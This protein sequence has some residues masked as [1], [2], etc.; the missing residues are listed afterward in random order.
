MDA[1]DRIKSLRQT[2]R[3]TGRPH[4]RL[5]PAFELF[6]QA[7][8]CVRNQYEDIRRQCP[9]AFI[10]NKAYGATIRDGG[11]GS[12]K[13][14]AGRSRT[15]SCELV[16]VVGRLCDSPGCAESANP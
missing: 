15:L 14:W 2:L 6:V 12:M 10:E 8:D 1:S 7:F 13:V 5:D 4:M 9:A 3:G 11:A 16:F